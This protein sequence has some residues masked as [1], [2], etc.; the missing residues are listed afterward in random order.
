MA[1]CKLEMKCDLQFSSMKLETKFTLIAKYRT[2]NWSQNSVLGVHR[3]WWLRQLLRF[4]SSFTYLTKSTLKKH[5]RSKCLVFV[6]LMNSNWWKSHSF[7]FFNHW[8]QPKQFHNILNLFDPFLLFS[9]RKLRLPSI[10][11]RQFCLPIC[12]TAYS[13]L[14]IIIPFTK[15]RREKAQFLCFLELLLGC[16]LGFYSRII[17]H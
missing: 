5:Q 11:L 6:C 2:M 12:C 3:M 17:G 9:D 13:I 14:M 1:F 7:D 8:R 15:W 10:V 4:I 16:V